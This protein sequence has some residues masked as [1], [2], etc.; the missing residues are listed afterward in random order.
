MKTCK[1]ETTQTFLGED[2][3]FMRV[4]A[5]GPADANKPLKRFVTFFNSFI[6]SEEYNAEFTIYIDF[7]NPE[8]NFPRN[9]YQDVDKAF[10]IRSV[11]FDLAEI[12]ANKDNLYSASLVT[13][14]KALYDSGQESAAASRSTRYDKDKLKEWALEILQKEGTT[15]EKRQD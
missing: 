15:T 10:H 12:V 11:T 5:R 8:D 4:L 13:K 7:S 9:K 1:I 14:T 6:Y 3:C 2:F